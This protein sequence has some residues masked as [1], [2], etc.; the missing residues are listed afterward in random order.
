M[1]ADRQDPKIDTA[2]AKAQQDAQQAGV[3][4][5]PTFI[6]QKAGS[7]PQKAAAAQVEAALAKAAAGT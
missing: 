1:L 7:P 4:S 6:I 2:I 3:N 5:T